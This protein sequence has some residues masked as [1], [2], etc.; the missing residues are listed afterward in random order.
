MAFYTRPWFW[1]LIIAV[2]MILVGIIGYE[3]TRPTTPWWVWLFLFFGFILLPVAAIIGYLGHS[4]KSIKLV[5]DE[6]VVTP[7][8]VIKTKKTPT[9]A[10][11]GTITQ[12]APVAYPAGYQLTPISN[13][14]SPAVVHSFPVAPTASPVSSGIVSGPTTYYHPAVVPSPSVAATSPQV[15]FSPNYNYLSPALS[16]PQVAFSPNYNYLSP[17]LANSPNP[18][19]QTPV[20]TPPMQLSPSP[21]MYRTA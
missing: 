16:S 1:V 3:S 15:A 20:G 6:T 9:G 4:K 2:I 18:V 5:P 17:A 13:P 12:T 10:T 11:V 14:G 7:N 19:F 8:G 21:T